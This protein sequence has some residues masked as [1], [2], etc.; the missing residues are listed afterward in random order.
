MPAF[1]L[2]YS[3]KIL[4]SVLILLKFFNKELIMVSEV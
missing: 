3:T 2:I 4:S 1:P